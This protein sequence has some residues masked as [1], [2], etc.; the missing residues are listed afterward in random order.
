MDCVC[1]WRAPADI[2]NIRPPA[3]WFVWEL[4][5]SNS[6]VC[7]HRHEGWMPIEPKVILA[8][9]TQNT[10]ILHLWRAV[11]CSKTFHTDYLMWSKSWLNVGSFDFMYSE[12]LPYNKTEAGHVATTFRGH[13]RELRSQDKHHCEDRCLQGDIAARLGLSWVETTRETSRKVDMWM[14]CVD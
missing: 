13:I 7:E 11:W 6:H 9:F 12:F 4:S 14:D 10:I 8:A 1:A 2:C 5:H 3:P